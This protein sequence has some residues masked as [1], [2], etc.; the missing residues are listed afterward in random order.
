MDLGLTNTRF[1]VCGAGNGLGK[2]VAATLLD[3]GATVCGVTRTEGKLQEFAGKYG[4]RFIPLYADIYDVQT[5]RQLLD[6]HQDLPPAGIVFNAGGPPATS[7]METTAEHWDEAYRTVFKWKT[8]LA[9][10]FL[11]LMQKNGYGRLLFLESISV[12]QPAP[13][14][15]LSN[16]MRSAVISWMKTLSAE[17]AA[18]G[19][20]CNAIATGFHNTAAMERVFKKTA[21]ATGTSIAEAKKILEAQVP[22]KRLGTAEDFGSLAAWLLSRHSSY[23]TG[24]TISIDGGM[25]KGLFG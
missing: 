12:K 24:Q 17:I 6:M 10:A 7:A 3:E 16:A 23:I 9:L 15:V 18:S 8:S 19:I 13:N 2:A 4:D 11:P 21:E 20:T 25:I 1:I 14:L 22:V 5:H